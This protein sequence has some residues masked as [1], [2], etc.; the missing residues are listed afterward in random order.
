MTGQ[1]SALKVALIG[2]AERLIGQTSFEVAGTSS[3]SNARSVN[4]KSKKQ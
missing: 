1:E 2:K 3:T 4:M